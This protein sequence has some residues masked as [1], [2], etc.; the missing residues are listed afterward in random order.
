[1]TYTS[2]HHIHWSRIG[3]ITSIV[4]AGF[5]V[6]T[7]AF[8]LGQDRGLFGVGSANQIT[9]IES[10]LD[11][12][13]RARKRADKALDGKV[14]GLRKEQERVNRQLLIG[15]GRIQGQMGMQT[16]LS[17]MAAGSVDE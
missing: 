11:A 15:I 8:A 12:E 2:G 14:E 6:I 16:E 7:L 4:V 10:A 17:R 1:M 5:S 3:V 13:A 9:R